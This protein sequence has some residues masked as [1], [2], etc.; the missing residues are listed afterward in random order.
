MALR[1]CRECGHPVPGGEKACP[2][3]GAVPSPRRKWLW[4]AFACLGA[5]VTAGIYVGMFQPQ[6]MRRKAEARLT[7]LELKQA[8]VDRLLATTTTI[9]KMQGHVVWVEPGL[10]RMRSERER[11]ELASLIGTYAGL[12]D[13]SNE[14]RCEVRDNRTG[15]VIAEW[16]SAR[17]LVTGA[18]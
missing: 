16:S 5:L 7:P 18:P 2:S 14:A 3:C 1:E 9:T 11:A 4:V 6:L 17:G 13:G 10:W 15:K 12:K 8:E